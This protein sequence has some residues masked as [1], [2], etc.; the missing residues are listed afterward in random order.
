M[1]GDLPLKAVQVGDEMLVSRADG[2]GEVLVVS[3][4]AWVEF[5]AAVRRGEMD[6]ERL[7]GDEA[8]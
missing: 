5:L 2:I 6:L 1:T 8:E 7:K 4:A 3:P